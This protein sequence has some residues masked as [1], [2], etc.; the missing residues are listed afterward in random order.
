MCRVLTGT[1]SQRRPEFGGSWQRIIHRDPNLYE[2]R[3]GEISKVDYEFNGRGDLIA[4]VNVYE[5]KKMCTTCYKKYSKI[6]KG[7]HEK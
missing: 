3:G 2:W 6:Y 7:S 5:P 1:S 4:V